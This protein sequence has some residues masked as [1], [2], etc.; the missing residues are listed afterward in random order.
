M[1]PGTLGSYIRSCGS[2]TRRAEAYDESGTCR[3]QLSA[4]LTLHIATNTSRAT[5]K[6]TA[7]P[8]LE[9]LSICSGEADEP[10]TDV[11]SEKPSFVVKTRQKLTALQ[12]APPAEG[13]TE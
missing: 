2:V 12:R 3:C 7:R 5:E 13:G 9:A 8:V 10:G 11:D 1:Y 6:G 4:D